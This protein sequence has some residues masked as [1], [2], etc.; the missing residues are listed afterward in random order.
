MFLG[1]IGNTKVQRREGK[2]KETVGHQRIGL[3]G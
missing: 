2:E 3:N 1:R